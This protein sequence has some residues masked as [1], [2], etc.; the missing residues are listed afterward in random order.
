MG[1]IADQVLEGEICQEC[2]EYLG[3]GLGYP[4]TCDGCKEEE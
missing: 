1:D 3:D 4:V 2:G